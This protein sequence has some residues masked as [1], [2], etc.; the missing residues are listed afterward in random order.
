[1]TPEEFTALLRA[2]HAAHDAELRARYARSLPFDDA[3]FDRWERARLLGF[4][5]NTSIYASACVFGPVEVGTNTWIGPNTMLDGSGGKLTIGSFCSISAG[6]H[7]YTHDT[8]LWAVSGGKKPVR[9]ES[10]S[11]GSRV[12]IGSQC[13]IAAGVTIGDQCII[14]ANSLVLDDVPAGSIIGG[15]PACAIGAV[16]GEGENVR[17]QYFHERDVDPS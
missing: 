3:L 6:V 7:I 4:G 5:E 17:L 13:V 8:V 1:M 14:S 12:Y 11:I 16:E 2:T 9:R 15:T 10:V